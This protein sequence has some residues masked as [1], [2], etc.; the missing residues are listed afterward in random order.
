MHIKNVKVRMFYRTYKLTGVGV[1]QV[2]KRF[3]ICSSNSAIGLLRRVGAKRS[4]Q[5][6]HRRERGWFSRARPGVDIFQV[7]TN[8]YE[9]KH[10]LNFKTKVNTLTLLTIHKFA[11]GTE[12]LN[13]IE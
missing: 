6:A 2:C 7:N 4:E 9:C 10:S 3:S 1:I 8:Y 13:S 11:R 5:F 12:T